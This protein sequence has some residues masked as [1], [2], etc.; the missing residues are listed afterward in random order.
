MF[1]MHLGGK[2][3]VSLRLLGVSYASGG[4][5]GVNARVLGVSYVF[6]RKTSVNARFLGVSMR[7][8]KLLVCLEGF[9]SVHA[10]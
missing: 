5:P 3:G 2:T 6:G 10:R 4:K 7:T 8:V 9:V 1:P